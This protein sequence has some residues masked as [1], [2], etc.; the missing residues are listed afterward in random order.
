MAGDRRGVCDGTH[1]RLLE[2]QG[3]DELVLNFYLIPIQKLLLQRA[4]LTARRL[5]RCTGG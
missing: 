5:A 3:F 2:A 1:R 4:L